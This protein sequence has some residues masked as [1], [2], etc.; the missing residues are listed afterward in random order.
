M[1]KRIYILTSLL[2]LM[3]LVFALVVGVGCAQKSDNTV[4][5]KEEEQGQSKEID[6]ST[7]TDEEYFGE[8][9]YTPVLRFTVA[10]DVHISK[11]GSQEEEA[12]LAE[13]FNIGYDFSAESSTYN[14]LDAC[15]FCGDFSNKGAVVEMERFKNI[16][17]NGIQEGTT[18]ITMLGNH[19]FYEDSAITISRFKTIFG[20]EE[21]GSIVINGYHFIYLSPDLSGS[22]YLPTT[23]DWLEEE[24]SKAEEEDPTKP[25]FVFQHHHVSDTVYGSEDWGISTLDSVFEKYPQIVDFSGHSH[26]PMIDPR[27]IYQDKY[28]TLNTAT[29]SYY[30]MGMV[31]VATDG[32]FATDYNGN[33]GSHS[34]MADAAQFY[35]VE[36]D[37]EGAVKIIGYDILSNRILATYYIRTAWDTESFTY[38]DA[39]I[40]NSEKPYFE[41]NAKI[42]VSDVDEL[43]FSYTFPQAKCKD[44]VQNYQVDIL[45]EE[46]IVETLYLLSDTFYYPTPVFFKRSFTSKEYNATYTI[47]ITAVSSFGKRSEPLTQTVILKKTDIQLGDDVL[48]VKF[49]QKGAINELDNNDLRKIYTPT[50]AWNEEYGCYEGVF[51]GEG[52]FAFDEI[53]KYYFILG[54][55]I[56]MEFFGCVDSFQLNNYCYNTFSGQQSGGLGFE[57]DEKG[58]Y[59]ISIYIGGKYYCVGGTITPNE[60]FHAVATYDGEKISFYINGE[61]VDEK[62]IKG[63]IGWT[64]AENAHYFAVGGDCNNSNKVERAF[65]GKIIAANIFSKVMTAEDV[66]T[67]YAKWSK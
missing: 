8:E 48:K 45:Q 11:Y 43:S 17:D 36:V 40:E 5:V 52:G 13:L 58:N 65:H 30:E 32:F 4:I 53:S 33:Y 18:L 28:T 44:N 47:R 61:L 26:F 41:E 3:V 19:E 25:I 60:Y 46:E 6:K 59:Y 24:L 35:I 12:R 1:K 2:A 51:E 63:E 64:T 10:S 20:Q 38:T 9:F 49:T 23:V 67:A 62:T 37:E 57:G 27:S 54:K 16:C 39:R 15:V 7:L 29:L 50:T 55:S 56:T 31:G 21:K 22:N 14:S 34:V 66:A 42:D